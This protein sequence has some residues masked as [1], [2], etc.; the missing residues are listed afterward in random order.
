MFNGRILKEKRISKGISQTDF[1]EKANISKQL[2]YKYENNI[3]TNVPA[4]RIQLFAELLGISPST[5]VG[6]ENKLDINEELPIYRIPVFSSAAAGLGCY[7][8]SKPMRYE[9]ITIPSE[10]E[11]RETLC[12]TVQG[13]SMYPEIVDGDILQVHKQSSVDSGSLAVV[14][15][16]EEEAV[17]K[18]I[19]YGDTWIELRS[20][21]PLYPPRVFR[22]S[23]VERVQ[24][25]GLVKGMIR[26]F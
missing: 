8:D 21:N 26:H 11:A 15:I 4:D 1:A 19:V 18:K 10:S 7:A 23:D 22:G 24:I 2:L 14:L 25:V 5:L 13:D 3:I 6:W 17:V 20:I 16:D 9:L 12:I